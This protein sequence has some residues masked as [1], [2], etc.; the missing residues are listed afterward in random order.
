M[1]SVLQKMLRNESKNDGMNSR[2]FKRCL[3][4]SSGKRWNRKRGRKRQRQQ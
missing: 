3:R 2:N 1:Q 4:N